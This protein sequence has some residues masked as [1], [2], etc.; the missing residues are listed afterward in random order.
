MS[1][2][3]FYT[4]SEAQAKLGLSKAMF[5]RKVNQ[6]LIPKV[7]P[8]GK[9]QS[10]YPK[11][12]IDTLARAMEM[13]FEQE[14]F[15]FSKSTIAEQEEEMYIGIRCFGRE[16]I[17]PLAERIAF[18]QKSEF[19]FWSLKVSGHVVG[20]VS[21]FRF[22]PEFLDDILSGRRIEREISVREVLP[23]VR[24]EPFSI[25]IDVMAMD[26]LL[27]PHLQHLYAGIMTGRFADTVLNLRANG[28]LIEKAYTVTA[29]QEGDNLV[30]KVGFR[31]M[32]GKSIAPGRTAYEFPLDEQGI[33]HLRE[34]SRRG[35]YHHVHGD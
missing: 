33:E 7:T 21:M 31:L 17:T 20:Y 27:P 5:H 30:R 13:V 2:D 22:P 28:Y 6:G 4:A 19:T 10:V 16:F 25:Y 34:L 15:V 3:Q 9:K 26:P 23:F 12:D 18:Q 1:N 11:R 35:V 32:E 8:P 24:L 14:K 29:T